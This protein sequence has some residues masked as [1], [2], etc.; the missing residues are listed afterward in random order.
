VVTKATGPSGKIYARVH[1]TLTPAQREQ[2]TAMLSGKGEKGDWVAKS[3]SDAWPSATSCRCGAA[4]NNPDGTPRWKVDTSSSRRRTRSPRSSRRA[5]ASSKVTLKDLSTGEEI[6]SRFHTGKSLNYYEWD[7]EQAQGDPPGAFA[8]PTAKAQGW[9]L[10]QDGG[11]SAA[12]GG[13]TTRKLYHEPGSAVSKGAF[14]NA[15]H[16]WQTLRNV[17][18]DGVVIELV[19]PKGSSKNSTTG[20][21]VISVPEGL[22]E[23]APGRRLHQDG[24]R[25]HAD[26]PGLGQDGNVRGLLR[27]L[28]ELDTSDVDTAKGWTDDK[29]F[30]QAGKTLGISDL[31]WQDVLVGV[32]ETTGKTSFFWSDRAAR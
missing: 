26:D 32:D 18:E 2:L 22:D 17:S 4:T 27:T 28:L 30:A 31:G 29:L 21:V 23:T 8:C 16:S 7:A 3:K 12:T 9:N 11:I 13:A 24:H 14:Q 10:V 6:T 1:L 5:A 25:L 19:D 15:S 20:T